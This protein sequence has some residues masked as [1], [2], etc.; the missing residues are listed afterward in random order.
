MPPNSWEGLG[1]Y[2]SIIYP[3]PTTSATHS[4]GDTNPD[5]NI[6]Q[7]VRYVYRVRAKDTVS[8]GYGTYSN[9][10]FGSTEDNIP[11]PVPTNIGVYPCNGTTNCST[12]PQSNPNMLHKGFESKVTWNPSIDSGVGTSY[13]LIY[14]STRDLTSENFSDNTVTTSYQLIG[15]L[16]YISGQSPTWFD[17]DINNDSTNT[18]YDGE[19]EEILNIPQSVK[20]QSSP[21]LND[22]T[23]Y[24]YRIV[25]VDQNNNQS[26]R[27]PEIK[28]ETYDPLL[29]KQNGNLGTTS[30]KT[31]DVTP[32][33][34]P[35]NLTVSPLGLD[36]SREAQKIE[37]TWTVS[38]DSKSP[39]RLPEG[40]GTGV[41]GYQLLFAPGN[42]TGPTE[43]F[44]HLTYKLTTDSNPTKYT[45]EGLEE[46]TY[47]Y[48]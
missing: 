13:Y 9:I 47:Y 37:V 43:D 23:T 1:S 16:P 24:Y 38:T 45:H 15:I 29:T 48:Y 28:N 2:R 33:T 11:P 30:E 39:G 41:L 8:E 3:H 42:S 6:S 19:G 4:V 46:Y 12:S 22:Y 36:S 34:I 20:T 32:P 18:F 25:A 31:P 35:A 7:G 5:E 27:F 14:R 10:V 40:S 44:T 26:A 17:N 21:R